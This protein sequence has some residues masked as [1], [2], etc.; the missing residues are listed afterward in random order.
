L[1]ARTTGVGCTSYALL[2]DY[3][4]VVAI[5]TLDFKGFL[6]IDNPFLHVTHATFLLRGSFIIY[7]Y[8]RIRM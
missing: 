3:H 6:H 5:G 4:D 7:N 1:M 8:L 2:T